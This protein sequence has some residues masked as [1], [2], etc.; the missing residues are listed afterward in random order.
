M[1]QQDVRHVSTVAAGDGGETFGSGWVASHGS[2]FEPRDALSADRLAPSLRAMTI[3]GIFEVLVT[4]V[5][6]LNVAVFVGAI[7]VAN[8]YAIL[9]A[10]RSD[11]VVW[12]VVLVALL[13]AGGGIG[14]AAYL[15]LYHDEPMPGGLTWRRRSLA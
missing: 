4:G 8:F 2:A 12:C 11:R 15:I 5:V 3:D 9:H 6:Y 7:V 14:T 13:L 10:W 1:E